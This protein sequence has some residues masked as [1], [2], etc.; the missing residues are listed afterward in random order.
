MSLN[1]EERDAVVQVRIEKSISTLE[2]AKGI[3]A[4]HY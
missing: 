2:E 1:V 3:A 4:M